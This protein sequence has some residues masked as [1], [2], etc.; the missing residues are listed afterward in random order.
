ISKNFKYPHEAQEKGIQGRVSIMFLID[1]EGNITNIAKRG[2]D[3]SLEDEAERIISRLPQMKPGSH[4]GKN[5]NVPFSVPITF[6]LAS[7]MED[8]KIGYGTNSDNYTQKRRQILNE[9]YDLLVQERRRLLKKSDETNPVIVN[10][11]NQL[12]ALKKSIDGAR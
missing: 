1:P 5:V 10:L 6:R 3:S 7:E 12:A 2:P 4:R 9:R 8:D 11:D